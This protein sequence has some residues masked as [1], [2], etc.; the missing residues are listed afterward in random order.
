MRKPNK[1]CLQCEKGFYARPSALKRGEG[2]YC[3][4][5]CYFIASNKQS[6]PYNK[7][8]LLC[9]Q[10]FEIKEYRYRR[11]KFCSQS[12]AA[13]YSNSKRKGI[14][15]NNSDS[16]RDHL[17][18]KYGHK[19]MYCNYSN[20]VDAHHIHQRSEGGSHNAD[21]N[22]ILLCPNHHRES[23]EGILSKEQLRKCKEQ[24]DSVV[25]T[26]RLHQS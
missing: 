14:K 18:K 10:T 25:A 23:H 11:R 16:F 15:Y 21:E 19:C 9:G 13:K 7:T 20:L 5:K 4:V 3:S 12:C 1:K 2:K 8:C 24:L 17:L 26:G 22:G 6:Y